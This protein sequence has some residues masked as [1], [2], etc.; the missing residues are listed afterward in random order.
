MKTKKSPEG[1]DFSWLAPSFAEP[2]GRHL[3]GEKLCEIYYF[4]SICSFNWSIYHLTHT[5]PF[6]FRN[7]NRTWPDLS[8]NISWWFFA[9]FNIWF[10]RSN[11]KVNI[12]LVRNFWNRDRQTD[13]WVHSN[14][15]K[16]ISQRCTTETEVANSLDQTTKLKLKIMWNVQSHEKVFSIRLYKSI[17]GLWV[18]LVKRE[19]RDSGVFSEDKKEKF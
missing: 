16:E 7:R 15:S 9:D 5:Q 11:K 13:S 14:I 2:R 10:L 3:V 12:D 1:S 18:R 19:E 4:L 17:C 6:S 8:K